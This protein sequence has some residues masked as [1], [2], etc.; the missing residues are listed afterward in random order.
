MPVTVASARTNVLLHTTKSDAFHMFRGHKFCMFQ[1]L[2]VHQCRTMGCTQEWLCP[3]TVTPSHSGFPDFARTCARGRG[4]GWGGHV[5]ALLAFGK[6]KLEQCGDVG[7]IKGR[8]N[9]TME[10]SQC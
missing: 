6:A 10:G 9:V 1:S 7:K 2:L 8:E 5:R 3:S 4:R